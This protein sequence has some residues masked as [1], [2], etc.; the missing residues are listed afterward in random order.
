MSQ[1]YIFEESKPDTR[2][3]LLLHKA[4]EF[5][6]SCA[7]LSRIFSLFLWI[8]IISASGSFTVRF[9]SCPVG[10]AHASLNLWPQGPIPQR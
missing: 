10:M 9:D 4:V 3:D 2:V 8:G 5:G 7:A 1:F 6:A